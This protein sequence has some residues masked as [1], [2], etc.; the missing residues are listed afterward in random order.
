MRT[1]RIPRFEHTFELGWKML[2]RRL[3]ID[4]P[5]ASAIGRM[6]YR[7][8]F[9]EGYVRGYVEDYRQWLDFR[10][11]RNLASDTYNR[12]K[13]QQIRAVIPDF[14][15]AARDLLTRLSRGTA[16]DAPNS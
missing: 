6:S 5:D 7:E 11:M 12:E 4:A 16:T 8:L 9:R 1:C 3:L 15:A 14:V 2:R 10:T 13:A